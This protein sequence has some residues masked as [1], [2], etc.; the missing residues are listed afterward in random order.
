MRPLYLQIRPFSPSRI[1]SES[2]KTK[3]YTV[4]TVAA[5]NFLNIFLV[6]I[7]SGS[8]ILKYG[9]CSFMYPSF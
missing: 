5:F 4:D 8:L 3:E 2:T 7:S 1:L 9:L 6:I